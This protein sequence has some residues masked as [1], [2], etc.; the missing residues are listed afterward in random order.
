MDKNQIIKIFKA[1][2]VPT[3]IVRADDPSFTFIQMN[4]AY[5]KMVQKNEKDLIGESLFEQFPENPAQEK[6]SGV[7]LFKNSF[8]EVIKTK[9]TH[10]I[11]KVRYDILQDDGSYSQ[12]YFRV[13]NAPVFGEDGKIE[14]I[15]NTV[16]NITKQV[17]SEIR[18]KTLVEQGNDVVFILDE[19][20]SAKYVS[21]S[22]SRVLG[23]SVDEAMDFDVSNIIHPDDQEIVSSEIMKSLEQPGVPIQVEPARMRH[24]DGDWRWCSGTIKNMLHDPDI[25]GIV[26][27]FRDITEKVIAENKLKETKQLYQS[28]VQTI[29]GV[30]WEAK[31]DTFEFT[32]VSPQSKKIF[33][34][35]PK[36]WI[37]EP[38]LWENSIHPEDREEV[39]QYCRRE[40]SKGLD[41]DFEYR[42]KKSTGEYVW[43]HDVVTVIRKE[44]K[45]DL[46]RGLMIDISDKKELEQLTE[47]TYEIAKIG[48]WEL[49]LENS[50]LYWSPYVRKLH[51][52][53][54]DYEPNLEEAVNFY[55]EDG[56]RQ[57][58]S[59][60]V[61]QAIEESLSFDLELKIETAKGNEKWVRVVGTPETINGKCVRVFGSTQDITEQ[62]LMREELRS[63]EQKYRNVVEHS[64]NM[65]YTHDTEGILNYVSPQSS[66]FL[67][68]EPEEAKKR[69][70]EFVT[71]HPINAKGIKVTQK[72]IE[73]GKTQ[74]PYELELRTAKDE[75]IWVEVNEAP[76][77]V[78]GET[79]SIIGSL[80]DITERKK[81]ESQL[82]ESLK[83]YHY[84]TKAT[85]D[86]I[87]DWDA[88]NDTIHWG[89][90]LN[91]LFGY[92]P[93]EMYDSANN[94]ITKIHPE[95][96]DQVQE[97]L[98]FTLK[99]ESMNHWTY[100]YR[101]KKAEGDYAHVREIG[102]II[103][104]DD[105]K[106]IRM[107]GTIQDVT[108]E[109]IT[110]KEIQASLSEKETLLSEIHH[111][112]KN[113]LA[114]VSGM[115]Q[116]QAYDTEDAELQA[117]LFDSVVRIKTM[118]T[119]HE[120]LYQ[121][122]SFSKL[123]FSDTLQKLVENI[124]ETL[125]T[126][127]IVDVSIDCESINLNIN[128]AI[129]ASLI[130][131]EVMTNIYKH[132]FRNLEKGTITFTLKERD[133][134][135][136]IAIEDDGQGFPEDFDTNVNTSLGFHLIRVL[137]EQIDAS[138][139][140][141]D[142]STGTFFELTFE[143]Q[144]NTAVENI[145]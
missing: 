87:Y 119:V 72:A 118:A 115:M 18:F 131:N 85:R 20:G 33:G 122:Q 129:P 19:Q 1:S 133:N 9:A 42:F 69:W 77:V 16:S 41:H 112:V 47:E 75:I 140:Y 27:N 71:D 137:S 91:I 98:K 117:K 74:P 123:E 96:I 107:I 39:V 101:L 88:E 12:E 86:A 90:G 17:V 51:E 38:G 94:W 21:P 64:T 66:Y 104:N 4:D 40:T 37:E 93:K 128:Q 99:D 24:K 100:E 135:I 109:V 78:N 45:P 134:K 120:L 143:R 53:P 2:P 81:Y 26:D 54:A 22:I 126:K 89:D 6:P 10:S 105:G 46:I 73:T 44:G 114:V 110:K 136:T 80:T 32:Y 58:I 5:L 61:Q 59:E 79:K 141:D 139:T 50:E 127:A 35:K 65:F 57:K 102:Y 106:A 25:A 8:R 83:R 111:R 55:L 113:N 34:Y 14:F 7:E 49:D 121:S 30:V 13:T 145:T 62:K 84:V 92:N 125:R 29:N 63:A 124:S 76:Y 36:E 68:L 144:D 48:N 108:E 130:V 23:Y 67:G 103:R 70:V 3:T 82:K 52:V 31:A 60:N 43:I 132:A 28:L 138:Y 15:I 56:S 97:E 11:K 142:N 116:L 95:D